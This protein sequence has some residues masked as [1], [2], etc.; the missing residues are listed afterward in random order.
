MTNSA[1]KLP[2]KSQPIGSHIQRAPLTSLRRE[3]DRLFNDFDDGFWQTSFRRS[4]FDYLP[5][6]RLQ[7][8]VNVL[9]VDIAEKDNAYEITAEIPGMDEK[10]IEVKLS[11]GGLLIKGEKRAEKEETKKDYFLS[12]RSYGAFE[13]YFGLPENV[14]TDKIAA[15]FKSGVLTVTLPKTPESPEE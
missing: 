10:D 2:V 9:A 5:F 7:T 12:E 1:T 14:D 15:S 13:R 8:P 6:G 11:N 4:I 3:I